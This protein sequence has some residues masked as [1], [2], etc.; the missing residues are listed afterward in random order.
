MCALLN[1]PL[2]LV[3]SHSTPEDGL[4]LVVRAL[5]LEPRV[6]GIDR[7]TW[8]EVPDLLCAN[9]PNPKDSQARQFFARIDFN[10]TKRDKIAFTSFWVPVDAN[11]F[12]SNAQSRPMAD[13]T[14]KRRNFAYGLIYVR[15]LSATSTNEA[16]VNYSGWGFDELASNPTANFGLPRVEIE[17]IWGNRLRF[18]ILQPGIGGWI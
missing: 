3:L 18:G 11:S 1:R 2:P 14:S 16:R 12:D 7:S 10:A 6:I 9:F 13:F 4:A 5:Q 8:K 15:D 17:G